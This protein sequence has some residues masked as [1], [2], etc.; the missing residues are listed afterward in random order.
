[1]IGA[2]GRGCPFCDVARM[3][4]S[5]RYLENEHCFST[6]NTFHGAQEAVLPGSGI[7]VPRSHRASPFDLTE[8][9][10]RATHAL[11]AEVKVRVDVAFRPDGYNIGWN[12]GDVGGQEVEHVHLHVIARFADEPYAGRGMRWWLKQPENARGSDTGHEPDVVSHLE[13]V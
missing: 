7:I 11:L 3:A 1:M 5:D 13:V 2:D 10:W 4:S 9:Q 12:V 8:E 6:S